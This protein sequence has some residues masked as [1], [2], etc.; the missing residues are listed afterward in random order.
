MGF[1][2]S[3]VDI[4]EMLNSCKIEWEKL[5]DSEYKDVVCKWRESFE[6]KAKNNDFAQ[7]HDKAIYKLEENLPF[8]GYLFNL[9]NYKYLPVTSSSH[10]PTFCYKIENV[11]IIE[12]KKLNDLH[13]II[14]NDDFTFTCVFNHEGQACVPE[15]FFV[16]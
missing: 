3:R 13:A 11:S 1:V 7:S 2:R 12:R 9:P 16:V 8:N 4:E 5:S 10:D 15:Y 6:A 14:C